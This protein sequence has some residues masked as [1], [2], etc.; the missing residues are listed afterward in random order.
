ML[1]LWSCPPTRCTGQTGKNTTPAGV[2]RSVIFSAPLS[3][4]MPPAGFTATFQQRTRAGSSDADHGHGRGARKTA[5]ITLHR[6]RG[7]LPHDSSA[8]VCRRTR[9]DAQGEGRA[10]RERTRLKWEAAPPTGHGT[11]SPARVAVY[12]TGVRDARSHDC[13]SV[14]MACPRL[15]RPVRQLSIRLFEKSVSGPPL[16]SVVL[17]W[18]LL[19]GR[20]GY[21]WCMVNSCFWDVLS[22]ARRTGRR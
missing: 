2:F 5:A 22:A 7:V 13:G 19:F 1:A 16:R 11:G 10:V 9:V 3:A 21:V 12:R 8:R 4:G 14:R 17:R 6:Q 18:M 15:V 20:C